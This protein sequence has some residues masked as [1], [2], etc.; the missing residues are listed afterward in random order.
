MTEII[1]TEKKKSNRILNLV[2]RLFL[3]LLGLALG[4]T[5]YFANAQKILGNQLPMPF[6]IGIAN[7]LS[8]SMEP[9]FSRGTLLIIRETDEIK[10]DDIVVYQ[11]ENSLVVHRVIDIEKD[12]ITTKGDANNAPDPAF[13]RSQ[14]R[15]K[16]IAWV[17]YLGTVMNMI[18]TPAGVILMLLLAFLLVEGSFRRQKEE[19]EQEIEAIKEE[20]RRLKQET[21]SE[22]NKSDKE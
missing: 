12:Q 3:A 6:G 9:V 8:G 5:I 7:V 4:M 19:G 16:V 1:K 14:V 2:R 20:I 15:G 18:R 13:D 17:P 21:N 11:A 10:K 22:K